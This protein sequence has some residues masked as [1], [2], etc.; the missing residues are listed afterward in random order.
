MW[1]KTGVNGH[2]VFASRFMIT[3]FSVLPSINNKCWNLSGQILVIPLPSTIRQQKTRD[4][5]VM[6]VFIEYSM[7]IPGWKHQPSN[8]TLSPYLYQI[9]LLWPLPLWS[10]VPTGPRLA[11]Q[12]LS[13]CWL[14][15]SWDDDFYDEQGSANKWHPEKW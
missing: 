5:P 8:K 4:C 3:F 1:Y 7:T 9:L 14:L 12:R 2:H 11:E 15:I 6:L 13:A 10:L